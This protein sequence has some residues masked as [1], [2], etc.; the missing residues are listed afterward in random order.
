MLSFVVTLSFSLKAET[1]AVQT[2]SSPPAQEDY[3]KLLVGNW[4]FLSFKYTFNEEHIV[5]YLNS[6]DATHPHTGIWELTGTKLILR[7]P[8]V[9]GIQTQTAIIDFKSP[10][11][12][13]WK[14]DSGQ[15]FD[16]KRL[17]QDK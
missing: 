2:P 13:T 4:A 1:N 7:F 3:P 17:D 9:D 10:D 15:V 16:V 6:Y 11:C 14:S 5:S 8:S 12:W